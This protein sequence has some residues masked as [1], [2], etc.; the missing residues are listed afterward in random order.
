MCENNVRS[1]FNTVSNYAWFTNLRLQ[2][3]LAVK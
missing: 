1:Q 3:G 2:V